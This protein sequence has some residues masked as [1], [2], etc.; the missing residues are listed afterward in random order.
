ML[1]LFPLGVAANSVSS[2]PVLLMN[3]NDTVFHGQMTYNKQA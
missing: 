2:V 1:V 3:D